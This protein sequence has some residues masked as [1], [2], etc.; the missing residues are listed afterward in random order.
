LTQDIAQEDGFLVDEAGFHEAMAEHEKVSASDQ[1]KATGDEALT[2]YADLLETLKSDGQVGSEG[3]KNDPY[4]DT[5]MESSLVAIV[6]DGQAVQQAREGEQVEFVLAATPF[7]VE[8]GGQVSDL[9]SILHYDDSD[10]PPAWEFRV[11]DTRMPVPGLIVHVGQMTAGTAS[12]GDSIW[13]AVDEDRRWDIMRNHTA[14]HLLHRELRHILGEHVQQ[15]GSL[16]APDRLRFDFTHP[17][18]VTQEELG[19]IESLVNDAIL[20]N[21]PVQPE[22]HTYKEAVA[23]GA[24]A[25]F[26]EK[27]GDQVRVVKIGDAEAPFS[28]E[29]CGGT[30]VNYTGDIGFFHTVSE[31]SVAAGVRRIEAVTGRRAYQLAQERLA[32][33]DATAAFL[34]CAPGEVDQKV[35]NLMEELQGLEKKVEKLQRELARGDF[36]GL[37]DLVQDI[38][39][40]SVLSAQVEAS[41]VAMLREMSDWFRDRL[42]SGVIVLGAVLSGKPNF[43]AAVTPDLVEQGLHAGN[44]VKAVAK[45]VG[46]GGGGR[47][48]M[49]QAGGR[50]P[51][52]ITEALSQVS[53]LVEQSLNS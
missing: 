49:A 40:V 9:G 3:V 24:M 47:P 1:F 26:G 45:E 18:M 36:E 14:T 33:L 48:T 42:G 39:G 20:A 23:A 52:R 19:V 16:V 53:G 6:R 32:V 30:H 35:L 43:I 21:Y 50:D 29:L 4:R 25:L 38:K 34:G 8:A 31:G 5:Q 12:Q 13:T 15:A 17:A 22:F 51:S 37:L 2:F 44:L 11:T 7:Y 41:D 46:G 10:S 27:Y 28:Q